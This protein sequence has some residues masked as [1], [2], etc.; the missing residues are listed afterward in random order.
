MKKRILTGDRPTGPLHLGHLVGSLQNRV[1]LQN[2]GNDV[3]VIISDFQVLTDRLDTKEV[4][5]NTFELLLDYLACGINPD[6]STIF[7]QSRVPAL[8]ELFV[9]LSMLVSVSR[10]QTNPTVKEETKATAKGKMSLGMLGFPV[11][12][13]ADILAFDTDVVPVGE[14]QLP[15]VEQARDAA[16]TFNHVF[17][18]TFKEPKALLSKMPRLMGLDAKQKMSKSRG[19]AIFLSDTK[20]EVLKKVKSATTDSGKDIVFDPEKKPAVSNLLQMYHLFSGKEIKAIEKMYEGKGYAPFKLDL[21]EV[22]NAFLDPIRQTRAELA[23]D[24]TYLSLVLR[25][26][27]VRA[28]EA[29]ETVMQKVRKHM[30]YDYPSIFHHGG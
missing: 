3:F 7:V 17:G 14:D 21:A 29:S 18:P 4:E 12:Q 20:E 9:Y 10:A 25:E 16:R 1:T 11:S 6:K 26:G 28:Q 5:R 27:T 2:E 23:K 30:H 8:A 24:K 15:H 19:N 22:I 13:A